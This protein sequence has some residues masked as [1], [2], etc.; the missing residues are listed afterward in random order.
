MFLSNAMDLQMQQL[1]TEA[2]GQLPPNLAEETSS[3]HSV[4]AVDGSVCSAASAG[5]PAKLTTGERLLLKR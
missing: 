5:T 4:T 3:L 1:D 2:Q